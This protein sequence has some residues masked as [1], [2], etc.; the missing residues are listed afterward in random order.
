MVAVASGDPGVPVICWAAAVAD[1]AQ[2]TAVNAILMVVLTALRF[3]AF[4]F[5]TFLLLLII[6]LSKVICPSPLGGEGQGEG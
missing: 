5:I 6:V 3:I 2:T 1:A 4:F